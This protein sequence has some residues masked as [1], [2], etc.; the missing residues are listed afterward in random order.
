MK[1]LFLTSR[2]DLSVEN[3]S[4]TRQRLEINF[5]TSKSNALIVDFFVEG[6][7]DKKGN[8]NSL[9]ISFEINKPK[10]DKELRIINGDLAIEQAIRIRLLTA[11]G[12]L[13]GNHEIGSKIETVIHRLIEKDTVPVITEL[14]QCIKQAIQDIVNDPIIKIKVLDSKYLDYSNALSVIIISNNKTYNID[15]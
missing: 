14:E 13:R 5:F 6:T 9:S 3:I 10:E 4:D 15:F 11:L 2:G 12:S 1:D 8:Q 7:K